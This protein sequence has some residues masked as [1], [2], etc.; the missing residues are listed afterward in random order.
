MTPAM[1][2]PRSRMLVAPTSEMTSS[3]IS[4][5]S[6][7]DIGSGMNSS[8]TSSSYSS[9]SACSSR[10]PARKASAASTRRLRSRWRTCSS[11]SS[12]SGRCSSFCAAC[13]EL[14]IR[15]SASRRSSSRASRA[16]FSSSSMRAI[17]VMPAPA[18]AARELAV[19]KRPPSTCQCRWKTVCPPPWPTLTSTLVV[20]EPCGRRGLRD[21][22]SILLGLVVG[23][24]VDVAE[25]VDVPHGSTR[26][27]VSAFGLM[28]R[29]ATKPSA[30]CTWSPSAT[31][32]QNRQSQA[33]TARI[34]SSQTPTARACT[35]SPT[36]ASTSHGV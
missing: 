12:E 27:C 1:T 5:I 33:A 34:P 23:E 19:S 9:S 17:S 8:S 25:R 7:S 32:R 22:P 36:G 20:V 30:S 13:N 16:A 31:S 14:R 15:L 3:M 4:S 35:S 29:I 18:R 6:S 26:R 10:P 11:S 28:S 2:R 24:R 21:E